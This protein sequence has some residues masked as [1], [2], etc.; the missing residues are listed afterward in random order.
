MVR[1]T[2]GSTRIRAASSAGGGPSRLVSRKLPSRP[3]A[4]VTELSGT[5]SATACQ[6][7]VATGEPGAPG[8][9]EAPGDASGLSDRQPEAVGRSG[10]ELTAATPPSFGRNPQ[11]SIPP[12]SAT[13]TAALATRAA[14]RR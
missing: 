2:G 6:S 4:A 12:M 9:P 13:T 7:P 1:A 11:T 5:R 3:T 8:T 10:D 14:G